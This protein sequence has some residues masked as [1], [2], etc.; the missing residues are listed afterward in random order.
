MTTESKSVIRCAIY[1]R[2]SSEEGLEQS[3]NSLD[4]QREACEAFIASQRHE[5]WRAL[6]AR[7]ED[8][9][10]SGGTLERPAVQ[11]LLQDVQGHKVDTIVVYKV[12]RLTRSLADFAKI[13]EALD[14]RGVSF[15]S[16]TQQF[17]TT[18][19]M[20]RLTLN[21]LLSFA[22]F[23]REVTGERIRDKIAAS[24]RKGMWM[25]GN[26]PLGY[27][28]KDRRLFINPG[29]AEL[30]RRIFNLYLELGCVAKLKAKLDE[31][32]IRSKE[33]TSVA[34]VRSGGTS[35]STGALYQILKNRIY[36]GEISHR[37]QNH[38]GLHDAIMPRELWERVQAQLKSDNQGR[39][40]GRKA[41]SPSLLVGLLQGADGSPFTPSHTSKSGRRYRYY[42]SQGK[43]D[44]GNAAAKPIRLPAHDI[45]QQVFRRLLSF[46]YSTREVLDQLSP[47]QDSP[48]QTQQ[49]L[50][51]SHKQFETLSS[52]SPSV[53]RDFVRKVVVR[54]VVHADRIE[55]KVG[56]QKLRAVL[57]GVD[58]DSSS[59]P[60]SDRPE[61]SDEVISLN[62]EAQL[63]RRGGE[64]RLVLSPEI[65][66][67]TREEPVPSLLKAL[68]RGREWYEWIVAGK[69][70]GRRDISKK[71]SLDE[72]Y[73]SRV[74]QC[75][76]L[77][78]D[79]VQ[80]ILEGRQPPSFTLEKMRSRTPLS[81]VEQKRQL[82]F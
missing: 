20:G 8:G 31:E 3:F 33:R 76:F 13:V 21:I 74:L 39:R 48:G 30:I 25:G 70:S 77:A 17:N 35:Y 59:Q 65:D 7:Y 67:Q 43:A 41:N 1:T 11:R 50:D 51:A 32:K 19:S 72:R 62:L 61:C 69:V 60:V 55:I 56:K 63:R 38:P 28:V 22:Q 52:S 10:Y 37:G 42:V 53:V 54:A 23:E 49:I 47:S 80:A 12:D 79:I 5:G 75:A 24:K 57:G 46:L 71:L 81:W 29:E 73:V 14:A 9:G 27:N 36:I 40:D 82:S 15:V 18:T 2:K 44:N 68:A 78:P 4:A 64:M 58:S 6:P 26:V 34:G 16:V 45:E 66:G